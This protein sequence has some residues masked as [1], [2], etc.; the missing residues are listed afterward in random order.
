MAKVVIGLGFGD[1]GKGQ[2][3]SYLSSLDPDATVIRYS[4]GPQAGHHV[5]DGERSHIFS[6]FGSGTLHGLPTMI[7]EQ[8]V[9]NPSAILKEY[10]YLL[11]L[12]IEPDLMIM[13]GCPIVTPLEINYNRL[14]EEVLAHGTCGHGINTTLEREQDHFSITARDMLYPDILAQK[15]RLLTDYY[16][17]GYDWDRGSFLDDCAKVADIFR[18]GED[19]HLEN[20]SIIYEGSQGLLLDKD[21]GFFPHCT[22]Y[23]V[24]LR[25]LPGG[26]DFLDVYY[27]TRAYATR[28]GNGPM[29]V[30]YR[31]KPM[32]IKERP[33]ET[34]VVNEY[35]GEFRCAILNVD[36]LEYGLLKDGRAGHRETLVITCLEH[37]VDWWF[38]YNNEV[39]E[40]NNKEEFCRMIA[41]ILNIDLVLEMT[42]YQMKSGI[43]QR[44]EEGA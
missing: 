10:V 41:D 2:T 40:C 27:V 24:G 19:F 26:D 39:H 21:I 32:G 13:G 42:E 11:N 4:G 44:M 34:N 38:Y 12:D 3:T 9:I 22:P 16:D 29:C 31:D 18:I 15:L 30:P 20:D 1:E 7:H 37:M 35:Q 6:S 25:G 17:L 36:L 14:D 23:N 28:H 5:V 33:R 43:G 8:C